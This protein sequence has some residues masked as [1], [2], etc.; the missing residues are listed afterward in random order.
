MDHPK[1][2]SLFGLGL[3]GF[4]FPTKYSS[5]QKV[6]LSRLARTWPF[7]TVFFQDIRMCQRFLTFAFPEKNA[8][9]FVLRFFREK[10]WQNLRFL[11]EPR[12]KRSQ[13]C[14]NVLETPEIRREK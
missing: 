6:Y 12:L 14:S 8:M 4:I 2:H 5:S 1:D 3:P 13:G 10:T 9:C 7:V 11:K